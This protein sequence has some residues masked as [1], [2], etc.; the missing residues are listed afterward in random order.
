MTDPKTMGAYLRFARRKRRISIERAAEQTRIRPDFLMR[1]ESDEF[2]FLAPAYVRGFLRS[3]A[4]FLRLDPDPLLREFDRL[5]GGG[6]ADTAPIVALEKR[7]RAV[8]KERKPLNSWLLAGALA[9][10][11]L[12]LLGIVGYTAG[13]PR[14]ERAR[15]RVA[16]ADSPSPEDT[17]T[18]TP[19]PTPSDT[20]TVTPTPTPTDVLA[21]SEGMTV[22]VAATEAPCWVDVT[23]DEENV[24]SGTLALGEEET[25][26]A[27]SDMDIVLGFPDGVSLSVNGTD[28]GSPGGVDPVTL[29]LP[30]D[31]ESLL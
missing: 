17:D 2:D 12:T 11:T 23:A 6:R 8:P 5:Y 10:A 25:F 18:A 30:E 9:A 26:V 4:R 21:L 20:P 28:L 14:G 22:T 27:Q 31:I 3:Y 7:A 19:T 1:M 29:S 15:D 16:G 24:F 13:P